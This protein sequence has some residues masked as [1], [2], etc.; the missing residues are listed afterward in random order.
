MNL[1]TVMPVT[2]RG[3]AAICE[4]DSKSTILT[5]NL[6]CVLGGAVKA[7]TSG[8]LAAGVGGEVAWLVTVER[9]CDPD[10]V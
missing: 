10:E 7:T 8:S 9:G 6:V 5:C 2:V 4:D 1:Y 3:E